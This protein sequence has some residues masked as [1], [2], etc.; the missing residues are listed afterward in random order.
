[1]GFLSL[2]MPFLGQ[3][4]GPVV[5]LVG[6][7]LGV[8]METDLIK[9]KRIAAELELQKFLQGKE[10]ELDKAVQEANIKQIEVN[11]T[12]AASSSMFVAGW[13][14]FIGWTCGIALMYH[15]VGQ[16]FMTFILNLFGIFLAM[17]YFDMSTLMTVL[18]G[19]LGLG[20]MRT[21]EKTV[22]VAGVN[23]VQPKSKA[24][25]PNDGQ[26]INGIWVPNRR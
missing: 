22:G 16:P 25:V 26:V 20:A 13:R 3:L 12:E 23:L 14:P 4:V 15:F 19:M 21:Y 2:L 1:M 24:F 9:E 6:S 10:L 7:K 8:D 18:M 17:P 5:N 11:N